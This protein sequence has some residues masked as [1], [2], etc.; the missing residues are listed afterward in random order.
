M[1]F[2]TV[3]NPTS[4]NPKVGKV[5]PQ[6]EVTKQLIDRARDYVV[7][8][9]MRFESQRKDIVDKWIEYDRAYRVILEDDRPY[10]GF[11]DKASP[12]IH[13]NVEA[14]V[15]R[16]TESVLPENNDIFS[17]E[18][19]MLPPQLVKYRTDQL[20]DQFK[21]QDIEKKVE[22]LSRN[23]VIYG[24]GFIFC[25]LI[26]NHRQI[27]TQQVVLDRE[28]ILDVNGNQMIDVDGQ[29]MFITHE[30]LGI[31]PEVD[32]QYFGP[33]YEVITDNADIF[34]DMFIEDIQEQPIVVRRV[35]VDW[36]HLVNGVE[37]GIYIG[38]QVAKIKDKTSKST[39]FSL[40]GAT[41]S[42]QV[43]GTT[44]YSP[45]SFGGNTN[46][47]GAP[48]YYEM[49]Q[50]YC[51][52][53][54]PMETEDGKKV[55]MIYKCVISV[56]EN[57][58][59]Q[60]MP[61]PYFHQM[62]PFIKT[63]YRRV[64]G[65]AYG[66]GAVDPVLGYYHEYNDLNN[67]K[68]DGRVLA[69]NPIK[70]QRAGSLA[71]EQ[72]LDIFPGATWY[73]KSVGDIRF[74][75]F[76]FSPIQNAEQSLEILEQRINR[77]MGITPLINGAGDTTDLDKTWRGTNKLISQADKKF[78]TIAKGFED[79]AIRQWGEMAYKI[80]VQ[81]DPQLIDSNQQFQHI[82]SEVGITVTGVENYFDRHEKVEN[83]SAFIQQFGQMP[84]VNVVGL[85]M[86]MANLMRVDINNPEFG[87]IY[88]PPPP[89]SPPEK[90]LNASVS[91]PIDPSKGV[92]SKYAAS[93]ILAQ[94]GISID[95]DAIRKGQ[96]YDLYDDPQVKIESGNLPPRKDSYSIN[97]DRS[98]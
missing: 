29:P 74:A 7:S 63:V 46:N 59:I 94:R 90:P 9:V 40:N 39:H 68:N 75:N 1:D 11:D 85:M 86:T 89:P 82:N 17:V 91:I 35:Y 42:E 62:K 55:E 52:F 69:I 21:K 24:T 33:G 44:A 81:F 13:D 67:Q 32:V 16:I 50:A 2:N 37:S 78:K 6:F 26:N 12:I 92:W 95:L 19:K 51:D 5:L 53:A 66:I 88:S 25:G 83:M 45:T 97:D 27:L 20:N 36:E 96:E 84:G 64:V 41:R 54:I 58:V 71:D 14:V 28:P 60:L 48:S 8:S 70:I 4:Q 49:F 18:S 47:T 93:Q 38:E 23:T 73:E 22:A 57:E 98:L 43:N 77:G 56:I 76:D 80:N 65:E 79:A 72:D 61:N 87:P 34:L 3:E 30:K 31:L 10:Q 15:S